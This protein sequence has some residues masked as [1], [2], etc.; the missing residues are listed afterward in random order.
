M[1][2]DADDTGDRLG[3]LEFA[4]SEYARR[5]WSVP[6]LHVRIIDWLE[7]TAA[8]PVRVLKVFRGAGKSTLLGVH[9]A[10]RL[11]S[12]P[13]HQ[14]L[15][16][17]ADDS[18]A[19]DLSRDVLSICEAHP[20]LA[21]CVKAP[22]A[23]HSWWTEESFAHNARVPQLR[24]RG[25]LSRTT[26]ARADEIINDDCEVEKNVETAEARKKLRRKLGE[27]T[28]IMKPRGT[29]TLIGTPHAVDSLYDE[30]IRAG[31]ASLVIPL[32]EH[33]RRFEDARQTRYAIGGQ[34]GDDG[35]WLFVGIGPH[36]RLL[37]DG[38]DYTIDGEHVVLREPPGSVLDVCSGCAWPERFDRREL[39]KRRRECRT[40]NE[41][42]SQYQL[43]AKPLD[44]MRLDPALLIPYSDEVQIRHANNACAMML[45][46]T[47]IVS[48]TLRLDPS[49]GKPKSDVSALCLVLADAKGRLYWH[50][51]LGLLGELATMTDDGAIRGGQVKAICDVIEQFQLPRIEVE[52]NGVGTHVPAILR[53]AFRRRGL[54]AGV[55]E[56]A[57]TQN[58][59]RR[60]LAGLE[61]PLRSG[62]LHAHT[63]VLAVV[64]EQMRDWNAAATDQADDYIDC[65]A[66][67]ILAEPVRIGQTVAPPREKIKEFG[68]WRP[69]TATFEVTYE[70]RTADLL[71]GRDDNEPDRGS[72]LFRLP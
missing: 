59:Q 24:A 54:A 23:V 56:K 10:W 69:N 71:A 37:V 42:D 26:G 32:F 13:R 11:H 22:P 6:A 66:G 30:A 21:G 58:K 35:L 67:A 46:A 33:Q 49:S 8:D 12:N 60:I 40:L 63:S 19:V 1:T 41:W 38:T 25:L 43:Q 65:A 7:R 34:V 4:A 51:A 61:P 64:T 48:A 15:V 31:A 62:Y 2:T 50:R 3:L 52:T 47:Q 45:G 55:S 28:H 70:D 72:P 53:G 36:S 17:S 27:Q 18:L 16:Q 9:C 14:I 57:S 29:R 5:G 44:S 39:E 68:L 20:L